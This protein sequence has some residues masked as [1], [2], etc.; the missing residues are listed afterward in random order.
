MRMRPVS[1]GRHENY[2]PE[3]KGKK[4]SLIHTISVS[5]GRGA[6]P[7]NN[8]ISVAEA[9]SMSQRDLEEGERCAI[10]PAVA[11]VG[12]AIK[13][14]RIA[15]MA[16]EFEPVVW[17]WDHTSLSQIDSF[18]ALANENRNFKR[19]KKDRVFLGKLESKVLA[20]IKTSEGRLRRKAEKVREAIRFHMEP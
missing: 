19:G 1:G 8:M 20:V 17:Q 14:L 2:V 11:Y 5:R 10:G 4:V 18:L 3:F 9:M 12:M 13:V 15:K 6:L 7:R 16:N